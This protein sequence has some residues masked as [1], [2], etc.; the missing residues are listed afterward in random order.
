[1]PVSQDEMVLSRG[2][3]PSYVCR[4]SLHLL[5]LLLGSE[6]TISR[7]HTRLCM[8]SPRL[9]FL[10]AMYNCHRSTSLLISTIFQAFYEHFHVF[11]VRPTALFQRLHCL[12]QWQSCH[13]LSSMRCVACGH[14]SSR[15]L[16]TTSYI[17]E[18][19][20]CPRPCCM[21][22]KQLTIFVMQGIGRR[23][24]CGKM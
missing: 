6:A 16:V 23:Q 4:Q 5:G 20:V 13:H 21:V 10:Y 3:L 18:R 24:T 12:F 9:L 8:V 15:K 14:S 17:L 1:M 19:I 11:I 7:N 22:P 2:R